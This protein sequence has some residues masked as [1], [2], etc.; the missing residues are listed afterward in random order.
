M[1]PLR[2]S[3]STL[4]PVAR[5]VRCHGT[6]TPHA[7]APPRHVPPHHAATPPRRHAGRCACRKRIVCKQTTGT[8]AHASTRQTRQ[9][10]QTR[11]RGARLLPTAPATYNQH[12][13]P[14]P[15]VEVCHVEGQRSRVDKDPG[16]A[17]HGGEDGAEARLEVADVQH[18]DGAQADGAPPDVHAG[19]WEENAQ[20][21]RGPDGKVDE[22][23]ELDLVR[24][25]IASCREGEHLAAAV[26]LSTRGFR[27]GPQAQHTTHVRQ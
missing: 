2:V 6:A 1:I 14:E 15:F 10:R 12:E 19:R 17:K 5:Q 20:A 27:G 18:L 11:W 22:R 16:A 26:G 9:T 13:A 8:P 25:A 24:R 7:A 3:P 21:K 4:T 23:V